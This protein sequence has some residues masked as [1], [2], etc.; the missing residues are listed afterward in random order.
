MTLQI[1][2]SAASNAINKLLSI[3]KVDYITK[4]GN[5]KRYFRS[6]IAHWENNFKEGF[7][8]MFMVSGLMQEIVDQRPESDKEFNDNL[9]NFVDF[10]HY[11]QQEIPLLYKKWK[12]GNTK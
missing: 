7:E 10:I 3:D 4:P 2:K 8:R 6:R 9:Q 11:M 12:A 5:R 1:S